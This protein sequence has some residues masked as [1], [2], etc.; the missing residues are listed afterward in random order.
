MAVEGA[1]EFR[2]A[3]KKAPGMVSGPRGAKDTS[4][5]FRERL[6]RWADNIEFAQVAQDQSKP[7]SIC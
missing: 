6:A 7:F 1:E 4:F 3:H 5:H 2:S